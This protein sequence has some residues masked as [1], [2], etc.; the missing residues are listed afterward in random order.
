MLQPGWP[1]L[2][3]MGC[4]GGQEGQVCRYEPLMMMNSCLVLPA[5][6][7]GISSFL[8]IFHCGWREET[9]TASL[10]ESICELWQALKLP[11]ELSRRT[12]GGHERLWDCVY[13]YSCTN[14]FSGTL[15]IA[16]T[17]L[18]FSYKLFWG[19]ITKGENPF[20]PTW[21]NSNWC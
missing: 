18:R 8:S 7:P 19:M 3:W 2:G 13:L 16:I 15:D 20:A 17:I 9:S 5:C 4:N 6:L 1:P 11:S 14:I 21:E 12:W 10:P